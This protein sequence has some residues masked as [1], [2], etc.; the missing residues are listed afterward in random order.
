MELALKETVET[1]INYTVL[2]NE[3]YTMWKNILTLF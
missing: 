2:S 3:Y 1:F